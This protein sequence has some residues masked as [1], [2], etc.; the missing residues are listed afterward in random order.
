MSGMGSAAAAAASTEAPASS[1]IDA[2]S[3]SIDAKRIKGC[4]EQ[5]ATLVTH[6][7]EL[8]AVLS[9]AHQSELESAARTKRVTAK[10]E[11]VRAEIKTAECELEVA[12]NAPVSG[13]RD[14]TEWLP[15]E[16][17][18][19]IMLMLPFATL[20][21]D[22]CKRVCCRW[23]RLMES[24]PI[25]RRKREGR[26]AAYEAGVIAP[27]AIAPRTIREDINFV[28]VI[29]VGLDGKVYSV[30][31]DA[32]SEVLVN[33]VGRD[34]RTPAHV[35][36]GRLRSARACRWAGWQDLLC[37]EGHNHPSVVE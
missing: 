8:D 31:E 30:P 14:P 13:G 11:A 26:W 9:E 28:N 6:E 4:K 34:W 32:Q 29:A 12:V 24:A 1:N 15:D 20:W 18:V 19:M 35:A 3:S 21:G 22:A 27:R 33:L 23:T 25:V 37:F 17:I 10:R 2:A 36:R 16:L 5:L 7:A